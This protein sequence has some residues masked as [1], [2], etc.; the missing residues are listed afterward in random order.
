MCDTAMGR[1]WQ[2]LDGHNW[3]YVVDSKAPPVECRMAPRGNYSVLNS[4]PHIQSHQTDSI[5]CGITVGIAGVDSYVWQCEC[6]VIDW[7]PTLAAARDAALAHHKAEWKKHSTA[8]EAV[9]K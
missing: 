1:G 2:C 4:A 8:R 3:N 6:G 5:W 9:S 7:L